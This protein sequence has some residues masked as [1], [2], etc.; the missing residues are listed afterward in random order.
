MLLL[1]RWSCQAGPHLTSRLPCRALQA[2]LTFDFRRQR[3]NGE[4]RERLCKDGPDDLQGMTIPQSCSLWRSL[5]ALHSSSLGNLHR[6]VFPGAALK[7]QALLF[8]GDSGPAGRPFQTSAGLAQQAA[9]VQQQEVP[10]YS[11]AG[12]ITCPYSVPRQPVFAVVELGPTQYKVSPDDLVYTEKL[13]GV[14]VN[15]KISLNRVLLLGTQ[16]QTVIGRPHVPDASVLACV[17]VGSSK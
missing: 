16:T 8:Q 17:E 3:K 10:A 15:E 6:I 5:L 11:P 12:R 4:A 14:D 13:K 9:Q 1:F 2:S 7:G